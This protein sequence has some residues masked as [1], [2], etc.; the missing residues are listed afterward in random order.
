MRALVCLFALLV[1]LPAPGADRPWRMLQTT[2]YTVLSQMSDLD[3]AQWAR[4][5]DQFIYST[6]SLLQIDLRRLTPLT[7]VLFSQQKNFAPY[8]FRC[9]LQRLSQGWDRKPSP[10]GAP[11]SPA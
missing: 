9:W 6:S 4:E 7:V 11:T 1:S 10:Q 3:T 5:Y 2:H 8:R